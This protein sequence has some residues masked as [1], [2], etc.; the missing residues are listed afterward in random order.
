M[1]A[2]SDNTP[3]DGESSLPE[4]TVSLPVAVV[5][6]GRSS[7]FYSECLT[8]DA[9][10]RIVSQT[11][12]LPADDVL[13]EL[14]A[15]F[16]LNGLA[17][18]AAAIEH[19]LAGGQRVITESPACSLP[20]DQERLAAFT[21]T[22]D[23]PP[24]LFVLRRGFEDP[25]FRRAC[26]VI[27]DGEAGTVWH[28]ELM[29][30]QMAAFFLP[31]D[32]NAPDL[33][34]WPAPAEL[35]H[36]VLIAFGSD[37]L[38]QTLSLIS[39]PVVRLSAT[40]SHRRPEFGPVETPPGLSRAASRPASLDTGFRVWLEFEGGESAHLSVDLAA[41]AD[42]KTGWMLQT[43][44]GGYRQSRQ[45][46]TEPDGEIYD[47]PVETGSESLLDATLG[48]L[49]GDAAIDETSEAVQFPESLFSLQ[50]EFR[51]LQ[52]L[53]AI[54]ESAVTGQSLTCLI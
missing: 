45:V 5:G 46:L 38:A 29:L 51:V 4:T 25:D 8:E 34:N 23:R 41:H 20:A 53:A 39:Q 6:S 26:Q 50:T 30:H 47:V 17:D 12:E 32:R 9:R 18:R 15:V 21:E 36:G 10:F 40:L 11:S 35:E 13:Q 19:C 52:L 42:I 49:N 3:P 7:T 37:L 14:A 22:D 48:F 16:V 28:V 43:T 54:R 44:R 31:E 27:A 24:Q 1:T 2:I 33:S